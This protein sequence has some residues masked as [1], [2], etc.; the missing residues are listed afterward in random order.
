MK[1]GGVNL[2]CEAH[3]TNGF[4]LDLSDQGFVVHILGCDKLGQE[5]LSIGFSYSF[6]LIVENI[7]KIVMILLICVPHLNEWQHE[8]S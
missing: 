8:H 3:K 4:I 6:R 7:S 2:V 1:K 5:I